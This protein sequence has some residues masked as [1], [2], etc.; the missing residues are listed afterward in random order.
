MRYLRDSPKQKTSANFIDTRTLMFSSHGHCFP[1][2]LMRV[3]IKEK[4]KIKEKIK[5]K[6]KE[7]KIKVKVENKII[8]EENKVIQSHS[9]KIQSLQEVLIKERLK[10]LREKS[11]L[12]KDFLKIPDSEFTAIKVLTRDLPSNYIQKA[13]I[14]NNQ[15]I[16]NAI[17]LK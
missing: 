7:N 4:E 1:K 11:N 15:N 13:I 8:N 17:I 16:S 14:M 9:K 10:R 12:S 2:D 6:E 3:M 5:E